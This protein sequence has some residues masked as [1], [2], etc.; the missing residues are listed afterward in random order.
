MNPFRL[1]FPKSRREQLRRRP[2]KL[3]RKTRAT[4]FP[5]LEL[6]ESRQLLTVTTF[7]Q[8]QQV[9]VFAQNFVYTNNGTSASFQS[10]INPNTGAAS[11]LY[12]GLPSNT[13]IA[14]SGTSDLTGAIYAPEASI[15]L[16]G[17]AEI[18]G[19][20]MAHDTTMRGNAA[21]HYDVS[22]ANVPPTRGFIIRSWNEL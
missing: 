12:F 19:A 6:L 10:I 14:L 7:A 1:F 5:R 2:Q 22:L 4:A 9:D 17:S 13:S 18:F 3:S 11:F 15:S 21:I 16:T 20:V 8:F